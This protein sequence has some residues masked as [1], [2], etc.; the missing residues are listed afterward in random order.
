MLLHLHDLERQ[1]KFTTTP[2]ATGLFIVDF[3]S[4]LQ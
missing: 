3:G 1:S 2:A 4:G